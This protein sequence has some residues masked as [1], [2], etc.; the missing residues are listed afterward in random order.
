MMKIL[1]IYPELPYPLTSGY[2]RGFHLL[3]L[4][5]HRHAVTFLCISKKKRIPPETVPA[6]KQYAGRIAIFRTCSAPKSK[7]FTM[8]ALVPILGWRL[9][10]FLDTRWA[11]QRMKKYVRNLLQQEKFDVVLFHGREALSV[12]DVIEVPIVVDCGD[13]NCTRILQEMRQTRF[14]LRPR[15]F[16][17]YIRERRLERILARITPHRCFISVRDRENLLGASDKSEIVPQGVDNTYWKRSLPPSGRNCIVFSGVMSYP[18]NADAA[19]FLLDTILPL[20]RRVFSELEVLIVGRDPLPELVKVAQRYPDVTVT[21]AV[22]D[23]R[24]YLERADVFVAALRF[25]SGVQNKVLEAMSM[26]VPVVTTPV[27]AAGL[28][29]DGVEPQLVIGKNAE[30]I[31]ACILRLLANSEERARLSTEGRRFVEAHCSWSHSAEKLETLCR[32]AA[33]QVTESC[34]ADL[35]STGPSLVKPK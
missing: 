10:E 13:T 14:L 32:A 19:L 24:Q 27:V 21:G 15:L 8:F 16:F 28:C 7:W 30:E 11:V 12:L 6:L 22:D 9:Q 18:P 3:R 31:A 20:V 5:G 26:E 35:I 2:L 25:A 34:S 33:G 4:M 1:W 29:V 17:H 23:I